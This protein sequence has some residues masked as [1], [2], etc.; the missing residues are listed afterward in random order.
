MCHQSVRW[1]PHRGC[2]DEGVTYRVQDFVE[3]D[4]ADGHGDGLQ[5]DGS[6]NDEPQTLERK[7]YGH[8]V[9]E[10]EIK[11]KKTK[12]KITN[13]SWRKEREA[14]RLLPA[15][16]TSQIKLCCILQRVAVRERE[17][18][19]NGATVRRWSREG[20]ME[21]YDTL[22]ISLLHKISL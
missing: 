8:D 6:Q 18:V 10:R 7:G 2:V 20:G 9:T 22:K 1:Q 3:V 13:K 15:G 21:D 4:E 11:G 5:Q 16:R 12:N 17:W 14:K 19:E